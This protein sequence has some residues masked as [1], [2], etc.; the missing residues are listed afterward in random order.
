MIKAVD[1]IMSDFSVQGFIPALIIAVILALVN[2]AF[3][4]PASMPVTP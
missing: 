2:L 3:F 1:K 4:S